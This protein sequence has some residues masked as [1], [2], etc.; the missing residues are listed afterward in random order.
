MF[1]NSNLFIAGVVMKN[2]LKSA[3]YLINL[4]ISRGFL[5]ITFFNVV[6]K[7]SKPSY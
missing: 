5:I 3:K 7:S 1:A 2:S 6:F 4:S